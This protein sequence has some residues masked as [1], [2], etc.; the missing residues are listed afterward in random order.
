MS[1]LS[2]NDIALA[3]FQT[4]KD[5]NAHEQQVFLPRIV[6]FLHKRRLLSRVKDILAKL[7]KIMNQE[8]ETLESNL[9]SALILSEDDKKDIV[10]F[11]KKRHEVK[12]VIFN[13]NV[14][15]KLLGGYKIEANDEIIDLTVKN[16]IKKLQ[17]YLTS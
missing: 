4:L 15:E 10:N 1:V 2:N 11:L 9:W 13:E 5:K 7:N 14:D 17:E 3:I 8:S 12:H 16:K 6:E